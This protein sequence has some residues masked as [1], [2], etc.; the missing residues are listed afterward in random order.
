MTVVYEPVKPK[1]AAKGKA[2]R[3]S[4]AE[5]AEAR[6]AA[7]MANQRTAEQQR[8]I[9][10]Y[11]AQ[12]SKRAPQFQID[13]TPV[14]WTLGGLG[15]ATFI[16]TA[17]LTADGTVGSAL[18]ARYAVGWFSFLLFG[19]VEIA[20]LAFMLM[21]YILGSRVDLVT[22]KRKAAWQWFAA[23]IFASAVAVGLSAY[24][25][26]DLYDFDWSNPDLWVGVGI[27]LVTSL[28]FVLIS[29]G[30]ASVLFAKAIR[31]SPEGTTS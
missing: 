13:Q 5:R 18:V 24:H 6:A 3:K 7:A 22:G 25:V 11:E 28:F 10:L 30:F 17:A 9:A 15:I 2:S 31:L 26:V 19:A 23:S 27:R 12:E 1:T 8:K 16:T 21:Y 29:K 20:I 4:D 14:L